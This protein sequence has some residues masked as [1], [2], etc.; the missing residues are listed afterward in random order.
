MSRP[1]PSP[2]R[3]ATA[4]DDEV[5]CRAG[6]P[7]TFRY[8]LTLPHTR[9]TANTQVNK[10]KPP[11]RYRSIQ[12]PYHKYNACRAAASQAAP[13]V[14]PPPRAAGPRA[15]RISYADEVRYPSPT[16]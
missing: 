13:G 5:H 3:F 6:P 11:R 1:A 12:Q 4:C 10:K 2:P 8:A 9:E 16:A 14:E 7:C 15:L